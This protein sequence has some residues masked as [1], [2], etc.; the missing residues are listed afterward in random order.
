MYR[1][2]CDML[3]LRETLLSIADAYQRE[4]NDIGGKSLARI[5][6]IVVNRGSFLTQ[7]RSGK[8]CTLLTFEAFLVWFSDPENWPAAAIPIDIQ[9]VISALELI[10]TPAEA[11]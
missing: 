9:P 8:T 6:T 5:A 4:T 10:P 3:N 7:L 11:E 2:H 1:I